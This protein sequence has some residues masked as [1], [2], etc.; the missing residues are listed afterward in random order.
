MLGQHVVT[1][2]TPLKYTTPCCQPCLPRPRPSTIGAGNTTV[3]ILAR[4]TSKVHTTTD[5]SASRQPS[6]LVAPT[7]TLAAEGSQQQ[8]HVCAA[9]LLAWPLGDRRQALTKTSGLTWPPTQRLSRYAAKLPLHQ[10]IPAPSYWRSPIKTWAWTAHASEHP[11]QYKQL[12]PPVLL[13][14]PPSSA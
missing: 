5:G 11:F 10:P 12:C 3:Q 2:S 7:T 8:Y 4:S 14:I 9:C 1:L 13:E 6:P